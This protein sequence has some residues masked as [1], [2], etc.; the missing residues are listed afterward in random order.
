MSIEARF[1]IERGEFLLDV[2]LAIPSR[3]VTALFGPSGCGKTT[4]LR[5]MAGLERNRGGRL[6]VAGQVWQDSGYFLP[7][8]RRP[9]GY[10]FQEPSLF[11]HL[12]V[13]RNIEYGLRRTPVVQRRVGF[14]QAVRLLDVEPLLERRPHQLSGGE[15]QRVAIARALAVSPALLLMDGP[16][17]ALD[18]RRKK[19]CIFGVALLIYFYRNGAEFLP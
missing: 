10:V 17:A 15:Q 19:F 13:R 7:A 18:A 6:R 8:H 16:L 4:L 1:R 9:L 14:E 11:P 3:G 12:T 5:A 2:D